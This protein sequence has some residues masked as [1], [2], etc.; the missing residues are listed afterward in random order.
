[1]G[2][3]GEKEEEEEEEEDGREEWVALLQVWVLRCQDL[4]RSVDEEV[5]ILR[6]G[7]GV[8][9]VA[10]QC[11]GACGS[12]PADVSRAPMKPFVITREMLKV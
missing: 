10:K 12:G 2:R 6:H 11:E 3:E 4:V 5:G 1:M 7:E 8:E 9:P